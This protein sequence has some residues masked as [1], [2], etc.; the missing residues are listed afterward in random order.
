MSAVLTAAA[1]NGQELAAGDFVRWC[2]QVI[3]LLD[4]LA[5]VAGPDRPLGR[6]AKAAIGA[7]R[8]GVVAVGGG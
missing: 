5:A 2:R 4:Q 3:D 6:N 7:V 1:Q 8:R